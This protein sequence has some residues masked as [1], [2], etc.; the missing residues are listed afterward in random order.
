MKLFMK[1]VI[2]ENQPY[3]SDVVLSFGKKLGGWY[4]RVELPFTFIDNNHYDLNS[5][6][7]IPTKCRKAYR[8]IHTHKFNL[9][10]LYSTNVP[11]FNIN[12]ERIKWQ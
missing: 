2:E 1:K 10:N 3:P 4:I 8:L 6:A 11:I 5:K 7:Y 9:T 12:D